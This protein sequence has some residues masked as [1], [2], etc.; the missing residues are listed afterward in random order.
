[1]KP[2]DFDHYALAP[3]RLTELNTQLASL[4]AGERI[5]WALAHL[6]GEHV[7]SSSFGAQAAVS[8]HMA[9]VRRTDIPVVLIDTGYLFRETW[10][11]VHELSAR[12]H[13]NL[14]TYRAALSPSDMEA[15]YGE[16]WTQGKDAIRLYN[17]MRKVEPMQRALL[18]LNAGTWITGIRRSQSESRADIDFVTLRDGCFKLHPLADW[19]DRDIWNYLQA[20]DLPYHPLWHQ[21]YVSIGDT[22]STSRWQE[23]MREEDTRFSG[24]VRECGLHA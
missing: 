20:H 21:G 16:L 7:L 24:L 1:M 11:F 5:D 23:G 10:D 22:H 8:L 4:S 17:R 9:A 18:D 13:L 19:R 6:P 14:H 2:L 15:Q 12:L 3:N